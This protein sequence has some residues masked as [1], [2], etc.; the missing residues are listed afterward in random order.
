MNKKKARTVEGTQ[1]GVRIRA[2][3]GDQKKSGA[4]RKMTKQ[5]VGIDVGKEKLDVGINDEKKVRE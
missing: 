4:E 2:S 5:V 1:I 3:V